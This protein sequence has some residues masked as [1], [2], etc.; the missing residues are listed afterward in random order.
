VLV[1]VTEEVSV[2]VIDDV[3]VGVCVLVGVTDDVS[4]GV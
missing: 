4:V 3:A 1:G 2:T